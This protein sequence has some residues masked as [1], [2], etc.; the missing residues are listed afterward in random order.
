[1]G[2]SH[3]LRLGDVRAA[4]RLVGECRDLGADSAAWRRHMAEGLGRPA[5][6][7]VMMVGEVRWPRLHRPISIFQVL[8]TGLE[9]KE[10][11]PFLEFMRT[12]WP[13]AHPLCG[14]L[15]LMGRRSTRTRAQL[16]GDR[17]WYR[18]EFYNENLKPDFGIDH[19]INSF[20]ELS[21]DG[22]S[23]Y[24]TAHR[25]AGERDFLP[26]ERRLVS[27]FHTELARLVGSALVS[28]RDRRDTARLSPRLR[29]A[30][31]C[32]L[33][34][35]SEKRVASR[36]GLSRPTVHQYVMALY[37]HFGVG[38]RAEMLAYFLPVSRTDGGGG[39]DIP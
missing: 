16:L 22:T 36:M 20:R 17:E 19:C 29:Q 9:A 13:D 5:G 14:P 28:A 10:R 21:A 2:K 33:R 6:A 34:G 23:D 38:S 12:R 37:R 35:D 18:T 11:G 7:R 15:C 8:D 26:R 25:A 24:I 3:S 27:F 1:M 32:L 30:L 39:G 31:D 4:F